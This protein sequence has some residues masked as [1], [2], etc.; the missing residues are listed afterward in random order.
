MS[1]QSTKDRNQTLIWW[2][3]GI[4]YGLLCYVIIAVILAVE[5]LLFG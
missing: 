2:L 1:D 5:S 3:Q 4:G